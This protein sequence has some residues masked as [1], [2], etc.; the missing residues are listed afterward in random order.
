MLGRL[1]EEK[2][3]RA[4]GR[5][6]WIGR[7][8][9]LDRDTS[10]VLAFA[11][12][13][14]A[15]AALIALFR[16]HRIERRY[17]V[18]VQGEPRVEEG[19]IEAPIA[20]VYEA[21]RRRVARAGEP[22]SPALTRYKLRERFPGAALLEVEL[23]TGRQHQIRLHLAHVGL[24]VLGD[25]VYRP[26]A[27]ECF[28]GPGAPPD[29]ARRATGLRASGDGSAGRGQ[30]PTARGL[31]GCAPDAASAPSAND[32]KAEEAPVTLPPDHKGGNQEPCASPRFSASSPPPPSPKAR[33]RRSTV[34]PWTTCGPSSEWGRPC[35]PRTER[36]SSTRS[37]RGTRAENRSNAD[38]FV[39]PLAGGA[40]RRLTT[41]KASDTSVAVSPDGRRIAFVSRREG[42][43]AAQL[44]L[45]SLSG[46]EAERL[47][48]RPTAVS[49]PK[50]LPDGKHIAFVSSVDQGCGGGRG[51]EAGARGSREEPGQGTGERQPPLP[52]LGPLAHRRRVPP[53]LRA[54]PGD[55]R[56]PRSSSRR[57]T[58]LRPPGRHGELRREPRRSHPLFL[59]EQ[60]RAALPDAQSRRLLRAGGRGTG[61]E[62][63]LRQPGGGRRPGRESRRE[64]D[65]LRR[66]A[67]GGRLARL[68]PRRR[69]GAGDGR[70]AIPDRRLGPLGERAV[71]HP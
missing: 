42:D 26:S 35:S 15:R 30:E 53:H 5:R 46:G 22:Q 60:H 38:I 1:L 20:D 63:H 36:R 58:A 66:R 21:G 8:H 29:A 7:L 47:T 45:L 2:Q 59:R 56:G 34:S 44:Y 16:E 23:E 4:P 71:L 33:P 18:L 11:L 48:D 12:T 14:P 43:A 64:D 32:R 61:D 27:R 9:R 41:S 65:R 13:R 6:A 69:Q 25:P 24:F 49:N 19:R 37:R 52:V 10:G 57:N 70:D 39:V 68:H 17:L 51:D 3:R 55:P 62:P 28:A 67:P 54:R 40:P 31:R 50:W